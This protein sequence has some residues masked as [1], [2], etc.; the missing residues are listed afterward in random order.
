MMDMKELAEQSGETF[1]PESL[2]TEKS[3]KF[4]NEILEA[5]LSEYDQAKYFKEI[6]VKDA[7]LPEGVDAKQV[8][9]FFVTND[10]LNEALDIM[11]N[12]VAPKVV[13]IATKDEYREL[14]GLTQEDIDVLKLKYLTLTKTNS[15]RAWKRC[16]SI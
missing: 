9:Q 13:D 14:L 15:K 3:Q 12:K 1:S 5:L 8:V 6:N 4:V 11:V 2:D 16:R 10:N 7:G